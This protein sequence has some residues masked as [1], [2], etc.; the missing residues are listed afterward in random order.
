MIPSPNLSHYITLVGKGEIKKN[1]VPFQASLRFIAM[2]KDKSDALEGY[3][4]EYEHKYY[5]ERKDKGF[6]LHFWLSDHAEQAFDFLNDKYPN[7]PCSLEMH[8]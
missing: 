5:P 2:T 3:L 4:Q 7:Y 1:N 8:N 6:Y